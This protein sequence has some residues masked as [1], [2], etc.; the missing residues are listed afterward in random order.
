[1]AP[2]ATAVLYIYR[3]KER[4]ERNTGEKCEYYTIPEAL[5]GTPEY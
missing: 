2:E 1:M 4:R 3:R 5:K